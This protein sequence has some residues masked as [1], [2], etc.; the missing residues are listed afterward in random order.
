MPD[1]PVQPSTL[2]Y[3]GST[4]KSF[5]A[6]AA[7]LLVDDN[8]YPNLR[9]TTPLN[10]LIREDF[11]LE[12][13][14]ATSHVTLED[15]LSH[16]TG[17]P[18][19]TL[20]LAKPGT[21]RDAVRNLRHLHMNK[22]I[23]TTW[24]YCNAMFV[25]VSHVIEVVTGEWLG[26]FLR[27]RL[28]IPLGMNST[29]LSHEDAH[30]YAVSCG[31]TVAKP[32]AWDEST[33]TSIEVPYLDGPVSGAGL[34]ISTVLDY[35]KYLRS[36]IRKSGPLSTAGYDSLLQPRSFMPGIFPQFKKPIFYTLGWMSTVYRGE[37]IILHPGGM[38]GFTSTM[39]YLPEKDWGVV[40]FCN[41]AGPGREV[42]AW[43]LIDDLLEVPVSERVDLF[44]M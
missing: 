21:V 7:S 22:E 1:T 37:T 6:A 14:Y 25:A 5:T 42:L 29:F 30:K 35:A 11:V 40:V 17:L 8:R 38:D 4:T 23:R 26:E 32:Y 12:D 3:T 31:T 24:Q 20:S 28:W 36:M 43:H 41:A 18:G 2:F 9:W 19:H 16:R 44:D 39:I 13:E 33:S 27:K 34:A 15:A 10:Q